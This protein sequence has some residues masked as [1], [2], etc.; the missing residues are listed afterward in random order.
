MSHRIE[1][2]LLGRREVPDDAYYGV[3]TLR[4]TE[5]FRVTGTC[6][7]D[8]PDLVRG[9]VEVKRAA[10][11]ANREF[12]VL[13]ARIADVIVRACDE[14]LVSG[15]CLDQMPVDL[16]Q[17]GAGTS[18][19]MNVNEVLANLALE[20]LGRPRGDYATVSPHRHVNRSQS[21]N[22]AYPTGLRIATVVAVQRLVGR[23]AYLE[24]GF[25]DKAGELADV[26]K[27]GRTQLQD[28]VPMTLGRELG[29]FAELVAEE[30][31]YLMSSAA[32]LCEVNLGGTAV[33][34]GVNAPAGFGTTAVAHLRASTGLPLT[35]SV[36]L[37]EAT[38]D[39]GAYVSM[40]GALK[41]LAVKLSKICNDLRLLSSGPRAGLGEINLPELQAGS[42]IM[43]AK[44]NP[45]VPEAVNQV[46]FKVVGNDV[47]VT[48]ASEAGQLQLNAME[49]VVAQC[50]FES[51]TWLQNASDMLL[52]RCVEGITA[53]R[54]VCLEHVRQ[55]VGIVTYLTPALGHAACDEIGR[56]CAETG[57]SVREVVL[58]RG[59][60]DEATVDRLL[61]IDTMEVGRRDLSGAVGGQP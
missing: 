43:P 46:C 25:R 54:E 19:N 4:A 29:A 30:R 34:T 33:G 8:V 15:R 17:G 23:L 24:A 11:L 12:G 26:V 21:T 58:E 13:D 14:I 57:R 7:S 45:V 48:M 31:R 52:A 32:L 9:M 37:V 2:D 36:D 42:S 61:S 3:H 35:R 50:L 59:L 28:A 49:P 5:N 20:L 38:S 53:N 39:C 6:V 1:E 27:M 18:V 60:L 10:A 16:V 40:H 56:V 44:I 51:T 41:R 47:A 55:S 22:D